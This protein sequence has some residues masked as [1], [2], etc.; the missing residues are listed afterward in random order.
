MRR[1]ALLFCLLFLLSFVL[2]PAFWADDSGGESFPLPSDGESF[3][4]YVV[5]SRATNLGS[6]SITFSTNTQWFSWPA[7]EYLNTT[8]VGTIDIAFTGESFLLE[9]YR[10]YQIPMPTMSFEGLNM[11]G[12]TP[13][14]SVIRVT[15]VP[16]GQI[17]CNAS[18]VPYMVWG[19]RGGLVF[20]FDHE[21]DFNNNIHL[22]VPVYAGVECSAHATTSAQLPSTAVVSS[23]VST[24]TA[25]SSSIYES[26]FVIPFDGANTV[27]AI[28]KAS[29]DIQA[30]IDSNR[31]QQ[32]AR[33]DAAQS[34]A[35]SSIASAVEGA[36]E[37]L[38]GPLAMVDAIEQLGDQLSSA[39]SSSGEYVIHF[40]GVSGPFLPGGGFATIIPEQDVDVSYLKQHFGV[41]LDAI[42]LSALGLCG[43][44]SLDY[45]YRL[46]MRILGDSGGVADDS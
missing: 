24:S 18:L 6:V 5:R 23:A 10:M 33:E 32:E 3:D 14:R 16:Y 29:A 21:F 4:D 42:G 34:S 41:I 2:C 11:Y 12:S 7:Y 25:F 38:S 1:V 19:G 15:P 8:T 40:P 13:W 27:A 45:I 28:D 36:D 30:K 39:L 44:K 37:T 17:A 20:W 22:Y 35:E 43:W 46:A 9:P 26:A 31:Q